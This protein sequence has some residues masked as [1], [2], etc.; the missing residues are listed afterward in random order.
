M[1]TQPTE[2]KA[3]DYLTWE[4]SSDPEIQYLDCPP[5]APMRNF[6]PQWFK[7]QKARNSEIDIA[8]QLT[9]RNCLG[10]R[11]LANVGYS[12]ALPETLSGYDT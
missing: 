9:I 1:T 7:D 5:P 12:I 10:F 3:T 8:D 6:M 2:I 4:Y 11:G